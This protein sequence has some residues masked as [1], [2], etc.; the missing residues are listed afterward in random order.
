MDRRKTVT[1]SE[2]GCRSTAGNRKVGSPQ[3]GLKTHLTGLFKVA[4]NYKRSIAFQKRMIKDSTIWSL[5]MAQEL[6]AL[7]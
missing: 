4:M 1:L 5:S 2:A 7:I 3:T 6:Q